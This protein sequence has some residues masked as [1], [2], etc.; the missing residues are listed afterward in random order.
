MGWNYAWQGSP[1]EWS[2][3]TPYCGQ[4]ARASIRGWWTLI[5]VCYKIWRLSILFIGSIPRSTDLL[6]AAS[7]DLVARLALQVLRILQDLDKAFCC[8]LRSSRLRIRSPGPLA[9]RR[10][11]RQVRSTWQGPLGPWSVGIHGYP[12]LSMLCSVSVWFGI[13]VAIQYLFLIGG[14]GELA[15]PLSPFLSCRISIY[16]RSDSFGV[17]CYVLFPSDLVFLLGSST[18]ISLCIWL[19][20]MLMSGWI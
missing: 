6:A 19:R 4:R 3:R 18:L 1:L 5:G 13:P 11:F 10:C 17:M 2:S 14:N 7:H 20:K 15:E 16:V 12:C 8:L 9:S